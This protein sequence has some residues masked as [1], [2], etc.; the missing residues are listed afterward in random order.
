MEVVRQTVNSLLS[1]GGGGD[2]FFQVLRKFSMLDSLFAICQ[3]KDI[4]YQAS[5]LIL[6]PSPQ[7]F[8]NN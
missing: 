6:L 5:P 1:F 2:L 3:I 8:A 4:K 7:T